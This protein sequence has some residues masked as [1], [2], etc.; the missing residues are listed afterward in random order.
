M[1]VGDWTAELP[2][3][4]EYDLHILTRPTASGVGTN[5]LN[6]VLD[7]YPRAGSLPPVQ[8][9]RDMVG[10]VTQT[11][12]TGVFTFEI[13]F[14]FGTPFYFDYNFNASAVSATGPSDAGSASF[15]FANSIYWGGF[16][17]VTVGGSAV[18]YD[19]QSDS[20][21]DWRQSHIPSGSVPEPASSTLVCVGLGVLA[22]KRRR[23]FEIKAK[24]I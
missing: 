20:G 19:F 7:Y 11:P 6:Q 10:I 2:G 12:C 16:A 23:I 13:P 1:I 5:L 18:A 9:C 17:G 3:R 15:N 21:F 4:V 22:W 14:V 8:D 24:R